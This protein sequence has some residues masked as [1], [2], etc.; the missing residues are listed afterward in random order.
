VTTHLERSIRADTEKDR[1]PRGNGKGRPSID[2][3]TQPSPDEEAS[4]AFFTASARSLQEVGERAGVEQIVMV[5]IIGIDRFTAGFLAAKVAHER[6]MLSGPILVRIL[7]AAQFHEFVPELVEWG[8]QGEVSYVP[9]MRTQPV[10]AGP[11]RRQGPFESYDGRLDLGADPAIE[12]TI[13]ATSLETGNRRRDQHLRSADFFDTERHPY[14]RFVSDSA[15]LVGDT[16]KVGGRLHARR[17]EVPLELDAQIRQ[18]D[19]ELEIEATTNAP[20]RDLGMTWNRLGVICSHSRLLVK[21]RLTRTGDD[22]NV[23]AVVSNLDER[24]GEPL[25]RWDGRQAA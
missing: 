21:G 22:N 2:A 10:A 16:L 19:G 18:V 9:R 14:V 25:R 12:L 1:G 11:G 5:S 7:R 20:H 8:R 3:A 17:S 24:L 6:A 23:R 4:T 15:S 13:D